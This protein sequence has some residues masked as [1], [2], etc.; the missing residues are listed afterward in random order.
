MTSRR[1]LLKGAAVVV[2]TAS[3]I[4]HGRA[5]RTEGPLALV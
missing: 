1:D 3:S 2:A 4:G 5:S